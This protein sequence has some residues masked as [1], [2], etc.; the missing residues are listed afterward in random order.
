MFGTQALRLLRESWPSVDMLAQELYAI[1][2]DTNPTSS[3]PL[4]INNN[5]PAGPGMTINNS[6]GSGSSINLGRNGTPS[7]NFGLGPDGGL[8]ITAPSVSSQ[9]PGGQPAPIGGGGGVPGQVLSGG[10]GANYQVKI[11]PT[12]LA[13]PTKTVSA[14]QLQIDPGET[15]PAGTWA[16][17]AQAGGNYYM[18][19]PVW[20]P[21]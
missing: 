16:L 21:P 5:T 11:Y 15:I 19:V 8:I 20:G 2:Q 9:T 10:P 13:G 12:G 3:G 17:V 1:F 7:V 6:G 14:V 4:T 18:E